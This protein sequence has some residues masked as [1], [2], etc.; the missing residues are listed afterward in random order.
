MKLGIIADYTEKSF[1]IAKDKGLAFMEFCINIGHSIEQF[2]SSID[3]INRWSHDYNVK[4]GS[5]GRWGSDRIDTQGKIIQ[6]ELQLTYQLIDATAAL[7]CSN[8]VCG[9]NYRD[10]L[11]YFENCAA[12]INYFTTLIEYAAPKGVKISVYNCRWNNFVH[13]DP[14]WTLIHGHVKE[15][16]IKYD[17]S[18]CYY[19]GGNYLEEMKQWAHRFYHV[20]VKGS[21]AI[22]GKRYDDPPA[23]LDQTNWGVFMAILYAEKYKGGLSIEPHSS[24]WQ[25]ELGEKGVD[26]TIKYMQQFLL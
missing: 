3:D 9:C 25:G 11:S 10:E 21:L 5:V 22:G 15:L 6:E 1:Q 18:H 14:A 12:A 4:V 24:N 16:G 17:P 13:S 19:A 20:H 2:L 23:G 7:G 26:F 8:F